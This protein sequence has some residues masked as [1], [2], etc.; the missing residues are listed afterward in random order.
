MYLSFTNGHEYK[1]LEMLVD[2]DVVDVV[3]V[4]GNM[5]SCCW[6]SFIHLK[7]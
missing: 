2:V 6:E 1:T 4:D 5:M 7:K 3:D